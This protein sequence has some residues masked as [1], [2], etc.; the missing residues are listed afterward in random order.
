VIS[1]TSSNIGIYIATAQYP[2]IAA[3]NAGAAAAHV[4][5][6]AFEPT[7]LTFEAGLNITD[8]DL[9]VQAD[10]TADAQAAYS[11]YYQAAATGYNGGAWDTSPGAGVGLFSDS[12][13]YNTIQS[14]ATD[15]YGITGIGVVLNDGAG[16]D[17]SGNDPAYTSFD[18]L[19]VNVNTVLV[20]F[21]YN[22]DTDLD[23]IIEPNDVSLTESAYSADEAHGPSYKHSWANGESDYSGTVDSTDVSNVQAADLYQGDDPIVFPSDP[24]GSVPSVPE[25]GSMLL[26]TIGAFGMLVVRRRYCVVQ[27]SG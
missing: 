6:G 17:I 11:F 1:W 15:P 16:A 25:P 21:T 20:K 26:A 2:T 24:T 23:G 9:I 27:K 10:N 13:G 4:S 18:G 3:W 8:N 5:P 7:G 14:A 12:T 19:S 22:G